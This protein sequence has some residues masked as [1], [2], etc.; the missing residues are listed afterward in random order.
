MKIIKN[1]NF[2]I[3]LI[4]VCLSIYSCDDDESTS[5][6]RYYIQG[7][8]AVDPGD[9]GVY[10]LGNHD[11]NFEWTVNDDDLAEIISTTDKEV[12]VKF[13]M[14]GVVR[15]EVTDGSKNGYLDVT[16]NSSDASE[17]TATYAGS[18]ILH[19]ATQDTV[20]LS[21]SAALAT[22]PKLILNG[23]NVQD[24]SGFF[25]DD[26]HK[27]IA[28]FNSAGETLSALKSYKSSE[29][30]YYAIYKA[31]AG[32]GQPE[33][34]LTS[35]KIDETHGGDE[36]ED[37]YI[38]L[39]MVDNVRPIGK[40]ELSTTAAND[41]TEVTITVTFNEA[42]RAV[43]SSDQDTLVFFD[44][45]GGGITSATDTLWETH[46]PMVWTSKFVT[47]GTGDGTLTVSIGDIVDLGGNTCSTLADATMEIDNTAP[48]A[49]G[50]VAVLS[51]TQSVSITT[52]GQW[53][54][55]AA[56]TDEPTSMADFAS[57]G[58]GDKIMV[59]EPG[60][61]DFYFIAV[62]AAGNESTIISQLGVVITE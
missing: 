46:D 2:F 3:G 25:T 55:V 35:V 38:K 30:E 40:I 10:S 14:S 36:V 7:Q 1:T 52:E 27:A 18:G 17:I 29:S 16:V 33:A 28:P 31:G 47:D 5:F 13:K 39:P 20:F 15:I 11:G 51:D 6:T 37:F 62:D 21:F 9:S 53:L 49:S 34:K 58:S 42:M 44:I 57:G 56:D 43:L 60:E 41:D 50:S 24:T 8:Q 59:V 61:Y 4:I 32:N 26:D 22:V 12:E 19:N 48:T 45:S 23:L 54:M